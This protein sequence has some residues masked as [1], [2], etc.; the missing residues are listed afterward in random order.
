MAVELK[1][2]S[3]DNPPS[4]VATFVKNRFEYLVTAR[5]TAVNITEA[6]KRFTKEAEEMVAN[7][8]SISSMIDVLYTH[9]TNMLQEDIV[10]NVTMGKYGADHIIRECERKTGSRSSRVLTHCNTGSLA[11]GGYGTALGVIRRLHELGAL[12]QAYC[13]ETRP[14]NQGS[15]LTAFELLHDHIP[16]TL[17]CDSMVAFLMRERCLS[18]VVV[19]ADRIA[20]NG[21]TANKIGTYQLAVLAKHHDVPFYIAAPVSTIDFS[22]KSGKE[23]VIEERDKT[24][25]I[26]VAGKMIAPRDINCWNPAFDVTPKELVTGGFITEYG[27]H[28][29]VS[30]LN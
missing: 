25:M 15:R 20:S 8:E 1:Q 12:E 23:I 27:V 21:D 22:I 11:C 2:I 10:K 24:E 4:F 7:K 18:A 3:V 26:S 6:A 14:Y 16:S 19:G 29:N 30:E 9:M 13:T 5:P 28:A 17:V